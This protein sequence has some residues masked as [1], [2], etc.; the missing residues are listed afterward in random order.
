MG[1]RH[2]PRSA[3]GATLDGPMEAEMAFLRCMALPGFAAGIDARLD[4]RFGAPPARA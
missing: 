1:H 3:G 4:K 2:L